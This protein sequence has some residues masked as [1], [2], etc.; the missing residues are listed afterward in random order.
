MDPSCPSC[1]S[2]TVLYCTD[3]INSFNIQFLSINYVN[4]HNFHLHVTLRNCIPLY[5]YPKGRK[6]SYAVAAKYIGK[7]IS[8]LLLNGCNDIKR[9]KL[10]MTF[11]EC[12]LVGKVTSKLEKMIAYFCGI[13]T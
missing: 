10:S 12:S 2:C 13:L 1:P 5:S 8:H 6:M 9:L 4:G 7:S 3:E 11:P